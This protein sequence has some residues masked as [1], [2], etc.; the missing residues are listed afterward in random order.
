LLDAGRLAV[1]GGSGALEELARFFEPL[2]PPSPPPPELPE[3]PE[4]PVGRPR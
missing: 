3:L 1:S 4:L 2:P